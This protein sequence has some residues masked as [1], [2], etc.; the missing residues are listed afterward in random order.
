M[1]IVGRKNRVR[2][3]QPENDLEVI[4]D[5][6]QYDSPV[7]I[8]KVLLA[9]FVRSE[10][11]KEHDVGLVDNYLT[12]AKKTVTGQQVEKSALPANG[13]PKKSGYRTSKMAHHPAISEAFG[14]RFFQEAAHQG[15]KRNLLKDLK[16]P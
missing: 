9:S 6:Q 5:E 11:V 2:A 15:K 14:D 1:F 8:K 16:D 10:F 13:R 3:R 4:V 7:A 12:G